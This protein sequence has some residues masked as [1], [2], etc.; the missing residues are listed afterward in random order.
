MRQNAVFRPA[1]GALLDLESLQAIS[2]GENR[3]MSTFL[4][5]AWPGSSG[6]IMDGLELDG[7]WTAGGPPGTVRPDSR[8]D[9]AVVSPGTAIVSS[10]AGRRYLLRVEKPLKV[11]WPTAAGSAVRGVL[12]LVPQI[13]AGEG[14]QLA[15]AHEVVSA[16]L[17]F[18][19]PDR[20]DDAH[21]LPLAISLGNG[22]DWIT[23]LRRVWAPDHTAIRNL[24]KQFEQLEQTIWRAEPEGS[25]WDRQVLGRNW[26]RYQTVAAAALQSA[27]LQIQMR[28][29]TTLERVRL[30]SAL[31]DQLN[32]S[33][34]RA[35]NE[36]LQFV[37]ATEEAS[38]YAAL[39][40]GKDGDGK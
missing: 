27:R 22:K 3:L 9:S 23:D 14:A 13:D 18:V 35:A 8:A 40:G 10:R 39:T 4:E 17:G 29:S 19:K 7:E 31:Y 24:L 36:L 28:P 15:V 32:R 30:L 11:K 38:P 25:V 37:G 1:E 16:R 20:M 6:L 26:V 2:T 33:V 34:E 12:A 21:L 5:W